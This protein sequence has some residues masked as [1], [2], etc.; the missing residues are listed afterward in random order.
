MAVLLGVI[1]VAAALV[2]AGATYS[3]LVGA[4]DPDG[5]EE[6]ARR[7]ARAAQRAQRDAARAGFA[8]RAGEAAMRAL[9]VARDRQLTMAAELKRAGISA[10]VATYWAATIGCAAAGAALG[11]LGAAAV[12]SGTLQKVAVALLC[13]VLGLLL[14]KVYVTL[15]A[16]RRREQ[17]EVTLPA[18][19][20]QLSIVVGAGQTVERGIKTISQRATGPLAEEFAQVDAD[21]TYFGRTPGQAL[22]AMAGRCDVP[23][24]SLF[25]ASVSQ[26]LAAGSP[27]AA[28]L[29]SQAKIATDNYYMA[30]EERTNK[31]RTK[32][33][34]PT[35]FFILPPIFIVSLGPTVLRLAA[36]LPKITGA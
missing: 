22:S 6:R 15:K 1:A 35:V 19:L 4:F 33:I 28:V 26:A 29:R 12:T 8:E 34:F 23:A 18:T 20:E 31:I 7:A 5:R 13:A 16:R 36:E 11:I 3:R 9:P 21:I 17:I 2:A 25:A 27:I 10:P 24:V 14:P 30:V 32:M